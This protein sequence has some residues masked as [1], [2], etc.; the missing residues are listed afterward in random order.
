M[1]PVCRIGYHI[2]PPSN[3]VRISS[4]IIVI[5]YFVSLNLKLFVMRQQTTHARPKSMT[6]LLHSNQDLYHV[7][8]LVCLKYTG[9]FL[10]SD[11][12]SD[13]TWTKS[14]DGIPRSI[15]FKPDLAPSTYNGFDV[16]VKRAL[17]VDELTE[18]FAVAH[19][20]VEFNK[21]VADYKR[22][23]RRFLKESPLLYCD[24]NGSLR[25]PFGKACEH[26][27][28]KLNRL[29]R[30]GRIGLVGAM[31]KKLLPDLTYNTL[32]N[33]SPTQA[34]KLRALTQD[35]SAR[36]GG[37]ATGDEAATPHSRL[38]PVLVFVQ[39]RII[40]NFDWDIASSVGWGRQR[41]TC[42]SRST[43]WSC[44]YPTINVGLITSNQTNIGGQCYALGEITRGIHFQSCRD[45][46]YKNKTG[47]NYAQEFFG[48]YFASK[49]EQWDDSNAPDP[50]YF[51]RLYIPESEINK[52]RDCW[53]DF[54][55][56]SEFT[57]PEIM[58]IFKG[59]QTP[60]P[61]DFGRTVVRFE[62]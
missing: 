22:C 14:I 18:V 56:G 52:L 36:C 49:K 31:L 24:V 59:K 10:P 1:Y 4:K 3:F 54:K 5:A 50:S 35:I 20:V 33:C 12:L 16:Q 45:I 23:V 37:W 42:T 25:I 29:Q 19:L 60:T 55:T 28:I 39:Q 8:N 44:R 57:T 40:S 47:R 41:S 2:P 30:Q 32:L 61:I 9:S 48:I 43:W 6:Q 53:E 58:R 34:L 38:K 13:T 17:I 15:S 26:I 11:G 51:A 7:L 46:L 62:A 21:F 27:G